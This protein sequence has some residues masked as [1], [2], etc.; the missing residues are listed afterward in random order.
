MGNDRSMTILLANDGSEHA[1]AAINLIC[2]LPLAASS[3][4]IQIGVL[5]PRE[6]SNHSILEN[7]L[8]QS[9]NT[10]NSHDIE[11]ESNL[12]LGYPQEILINEA[13]GIKPDLMIIGAKGLRST[14]GILLGGVAQQIVEYACCPTLVVR[15]PY[16]G[17]KRL[18]F[19][20]DGSSSS[21]YALDYLTGRMN[22]IT[23]EPCQR[24]LIPFETKMDIVHVCPP[25]PSP[26]LISR[27]WS[28]STEILPAYIYDEDFHEKWIKEQEPRGMTILNQAVNELT[29]CGYNAEGKL[30]WGDAATEIID[31]VNQKSI[32]VIITGSRGLSQLRG[33]LLGSVTRKLVHYS[34]CSVLI[35]K[36]FP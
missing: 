34:S 8:E 1:K 10:L 7:I 24:L 30:L 32:D 22:E 26:E 14:L 6:S 36:Q 20:T 16:T 27:S 5:L 29:K 23:T 9:K 35:V 13:E 31:Y 12:I 15:A 25:V 18:L 2:D 19:A 28:L 4:V 3:K 17:L 21:Q 11:V 33:L